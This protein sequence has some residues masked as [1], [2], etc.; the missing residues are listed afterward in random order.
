MS[1]GSL[2][3]PQRGWCWFG[4]VRKISGAKQAK[5][6]GKTDPG[7]LKICGRVNKEKGKPYSSFFKAFS[8]SGKSP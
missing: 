2:R 4:A 3:K 6:G 7:T 5:T 8:N 1:S